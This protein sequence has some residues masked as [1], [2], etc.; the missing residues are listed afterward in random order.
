MDF[1]EFIEREGVEALAELCGVTPRA[2]EGWRYRARRPK[3]D[4]APVL[5]AASKGDLTWLDIYPPR[6]Q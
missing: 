1:K 4:M 2:V 6:P 5:I 3:P